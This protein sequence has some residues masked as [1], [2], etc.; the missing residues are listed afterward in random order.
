[1]TV[2]TMDTTSRQKIFAL[3]CK[4]QSITVSELGHYLKM[5]PANIRYHLSMLRSEGLIERIDLRPQASR[6]RPE[7]V[8]AINKLFKEDGLGNLIEGI[9]NTLGSN[10]SSGEMDLKYR[11][12]ATY[13]AGSAKRSENIGLTM[14]LTN[15]IAHLNKLGYRAHWEAGVSG[16]HIHF[17]NC[18]YRKIINRQPKLCLM[19]A[20]LLEEITGLKISQISKLERNER[21]LFYCSFSG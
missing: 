11:E 16:P 10:I 6:G 20:Y 3:V 9:L 18:P 21:G 17:G 5:T 19:D 7:A 1:M 13:L 2:D 12:V 15:C 14:R 8:F 4:H